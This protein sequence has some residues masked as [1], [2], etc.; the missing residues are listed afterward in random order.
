[1]AGRLPLREIALLVTVTTVGLSLA[2]Q[3]WRSRFPIID[4]PI[5]FDSA[6]DLIASGTIP[7]YGHATT[8]FSF[9]PPGTAWLLVPGMLVFE[10]VRLFDV[11]G[12]AVLYIATLIGVFRLTLINFGAACARLAVVLVGLSEPALG[13]AATIWPAGHPVYYVWAVYFTQRWL[14]R[15][16]ARHLASALTIWGAG[17]YHFMTIAPIVLIVIAVWVLYRPPLRLTPLVI[18]GL[19]V[20]GIWAPYL[21]F[22]AGRGFVDLESQ[23]LRRSLL[24]A[25]F[26]DTWCNPRAVL[27]GPTDEPASAA[28]DQLRP[29]GM[30]GE[31]TWRSAL[32]RSLR[33]VQERAGTARDGLLSNFELASSPLPWADV[34]LLVTVLAGAVALTRSSGQW[35][36]GRAYHWWRCCRTPLG[37][38]VIVGGMLANEFVVRRYLSPDGVLESSTV[39]AIRLWQ[40]ILLSGGLLLLI[41]RLRFVIPKAP[42]LVLS[43]CVP[44]VFLIVAVEPGRPERFGWLWP[45][46]VIVLSAV[47]THFHAL[48]TSV[49]SRAIVLGVKALLIGVLVLTPAWSRAV[50]WSRAGWGGIDAEEIDVVRYVAHQ[51]QEAGRRE[52]AIGY[53]MFTLNDHPARWNVVDPRYKVGTEFDLLFKHQHGIV[54][55]TRCAEGASPDDEYRIVQ[56]RADRFWAAHRHQF[57]VPLDDNFRL[58][59]RFD[60]YEVFKRLPRTEPHR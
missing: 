14:T 45:L 33:R 23:V 52:A 26:R 38:S 6:R 1:V 40:A 36:S 54:N 12:A 48:P 22:E 47:I 42:V 43:L 30:S 7:M 27:R 20:L 28:A 29:A 3:G 8:Y 25:N 41:G 59:Q 2:L 53:Q 32:S 5:L 58:V 57:D 11:V 17:L 9:A 50:S 56:T 35:E 34:G 13:Y 16:D 31:Q 49:F 15:R 60:V 21:K 19:V 4:Y 18:G 39:W 46:P 24:P 55:T 44:W 10:D 37:I 51:L